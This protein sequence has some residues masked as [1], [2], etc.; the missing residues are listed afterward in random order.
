METHVKTEKT[1]ARDLFLRT[2]A[3]LGLIAIL[4]LGAW[5]IIQLAFAIPT[6]FS[7]LGGSIS[8]LFTTTPG[9][10]TT[11]TKEA[12][13][14]TVPTTATAVRVSKFLGCTKTPTSQASTRTHFR[15]LAKADL[16]LRRLFLTAASSRYLAI[17]CLTM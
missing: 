17:H 4:L 1:P 3:V 13:T 8:S 16:P 5:G 9:T 10:N 14:V 6:V 7:N 15:T 2:V 12:I 11:A